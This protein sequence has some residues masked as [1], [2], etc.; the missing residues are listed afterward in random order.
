VT[1]RLIGVFALGNMSGSVRRIAVGMS[2]VGMVLL[3][4]LN[5]VF[6]EVEAGIDVE[7]VA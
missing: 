5:Q 1:I 3:G 2:R 4:G 7:D 6:V